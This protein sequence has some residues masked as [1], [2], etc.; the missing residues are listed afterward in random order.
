MKYATVRTREGLSQAEQQAL[1]Q[2]AEALKPWKVLDVTYT[3]EG[4]LVV[5]TTA[6]S[7]EERERKLLRKMAKVGTEILL[8]TGVY[9]LLEPQ[10]EQDVHTDR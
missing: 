4:Y 6:A 1:G 2:Y 10:H 8:N 3:H 7:D 5:I 9:I